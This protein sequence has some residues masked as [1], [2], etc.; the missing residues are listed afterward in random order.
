MSFKL[1]AR[2]CETARY[3]LMGTGSFSNV[4][5]PGR[6]DDHPP[7]SSPEAANGPVL[8]GRNSSAPAQACY[9]V[10]FVFACYHNQED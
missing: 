7:P 8:Y 3:Y 10:T 1:L 4:K 5:W 2:I 6:V 9:G